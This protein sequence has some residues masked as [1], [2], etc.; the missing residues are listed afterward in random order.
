MFIGGKMEKQYKIL[1]LVWMILSAWAFI[2]HVFFQSHL[3]AT[4]GWVYAPGWQRE[5][6]F[7][8]LGIIILSILVF[9]S[10]QS[11]KNT[12]LPAILILSAL[13][14]ANHLYAAVQFPLAIGHKVAFYLNVWPL[15]WAAIL[16][17]FEKTKREID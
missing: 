2:L 17:T 14:A 1:V 12:V 7:W 6:G 3:A 9:K 13:F 8:N 15:I 16:F 5:I 11:L 10:G 4:T